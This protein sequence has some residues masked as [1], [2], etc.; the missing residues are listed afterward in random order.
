MKKTIIATALIFSSLTFA[1]TYVC[2]VKNT[3][4]TVTFGFVKELKNEDGWDRVSQFKLSLQTTELPFP[5]HVEY[6]T[7]KEG[8]VWFTYASETTDI[9]FGMYMDENE[10]VS[11]TLKGKEYVFSNCNYY[12]FNQQ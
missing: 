3:D 7:V 1:E 8:D 11:F 4:E 6:G 2:E 5:N 9:E 10:E 12:D